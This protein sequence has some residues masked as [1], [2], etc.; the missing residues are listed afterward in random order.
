MDVST[1]RPLT[2][3]LD[4][5]RFRHVEAIILSMTPEK[6]RKVNT[7]NGSARARV[8]FFVGLFAVA[9][10]LAGQAGDACR[11]EVVPGV[12]WWGTD[13]Y[14]TAERLVSYPAPVLWF[15]P[16]EPSLEG[17][18]GPEIL[19]PEPFK[20]DEPAAGPVL[21]YQITDI[22]VRE[23]AD[24]AEAFRRD[25]QDIGASLIDLRS[26]VGA[27]V[28]FYAYYETEEGLGAHPHDIEPAGFRVAVLRGT[29]VTDLA[30]DCPDDLYLVTVTR[31]TG[32]AHGLVWYWNV[33][34]TDETT[35]FPMHLL[36]EEGKHAFA[37][38]KNSD[39]VFTPAYDVNVRINDAWGVRD[40][41]RTGMLFS[42]GY[43]PWMAKNRRPEH[44]VLPPLPE[45][46][47]LRAGLAE[48]VD[49]IE[50]AVY[51]L[52]PFPSV[53]L[54]AEDAD[55]VYLMENQAE[56]DW[57]EMGRIDDAEQF[58][59]FME[60]GAVLKSFS[61]S[62][63]ADGDIGFSF[64]FPFF[65]VAHLNEPMSGGYIV[66]RMYLKDTNLRD[67]G[68]TVVYMPSA[69]RWVDTYVAAGYEAEAVDNED[70]SVTRSRD[71]V[72]ETGFKFRANLAYT[73]LRFLPFTDFWG[74]RLGLKN[75][76]FWTVDR[77]TYVIE[78][79]AGPF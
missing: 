44:R 35:S 1:P 62:A 4:P 23:L 9:A 52:R 36:V 26:V 65:V 45:D 30:G 2:Q 31:T 27:E 64:V 14:L 12:V 66:H 32:K 3:N 60:E 48:R 41:I 79:G 53:E 78:I 10:P 46:S 75:R 40:I 24:E 37:T 51:E 29:D 6:R 70:G 72:L 63:Y 61:L 57:P 77:L 34:D 56:R 7:L 55:L 59:Q 28:A 18:D 76:G 19:H 74:V 43:Q 17:A 22:K 68:W 49:G 33:L 50:L 21:Y 16:D 67:F 5:E 15:S 73:P 38:D 54:A 42:G 58:V 20:F 47:P 71:F 13:R 25:E 69:S 11:P 8:A 39:G